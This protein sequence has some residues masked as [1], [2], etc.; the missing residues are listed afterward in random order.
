MKSQ[1]SLSLVAPLSA[2]LLSLA[3]FASTARAQTASIITPGTA[4]T[5]TIGF[6]VSSTAERPFKVV[7]SNEVHSGVIEKTS[8]KTKDLLE[9]L[10]AEGYIPGPLQ[11]W[12]IEL[13]NP[14]PRSSEGE[15][16]FYAVKAGVTPVRLPSSVLRLA[17]EMPGYAE[18]YSETYDNEGVLISAKT[19]AFRQPGGLQGSYVI[20]GSEFSMVGVLSGSDKTGPVKIGTATYF[21]YYTLNSA[22]ITGMIGSI[23][24]SED[25]EGDD[26]VMEGTFSVSAE[27][28]IDV[29]AYLSEV[30]NN[31]LE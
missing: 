17:G 10:I 7:G 18:T 28:P 25:P 2:V 8:Y 27:K 6:T 26:L 1:S 21:F 14:D 19:S 20:D 5:V 22:K 29:T 23:D 15:R 16:Y 3:G 30:V 13:V 11:G 9:D 4:A 12:K 24:D 31:G